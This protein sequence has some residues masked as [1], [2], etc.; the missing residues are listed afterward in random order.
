MQVQPHVRWTKLSGR[1]SLRLEW[2]NALQHHKI[3][4]RSS[5]H[6]RTCR[7][8]LLRIHYE[9]EVKEYTEVSTTSVPDLPTRTTRK[10][11]RSDPVE[12]ARVSA[13]W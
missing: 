2:T 10:D 3:G 13:L 8:S 7:L 9:K 12:A 1:T 4:L 6:D 5:H 11:L